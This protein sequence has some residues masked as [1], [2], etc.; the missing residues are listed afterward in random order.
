MSKEK[1]QVRS[2]GGAGKL[3]VRERRRRQQQRQRMTTLL[4]IA[5][6]VLV[7]AGILAAP[8]L[9]QALAPVGEVA[10]PPARTL[11]TTNDNTMGDPNAPVTVVEFS[12]FQ[13]PACRAFFTQ[14]EEPF[15][16]EYV[17]TGKVYFVYRSMGVWIGQESADAAEAAYCAGE[18]NKFWEYH[19]FLFA[20]QTGENVG[21]FLQKR[22]IAFA[23]KIDGL[24]VGAFKDCLNSNKYAQKVNADGAEGRQMGVRGTPTLFV[25]LTGSDTP[26]QP[27]QGVPAMADFRQILDAALQ[28]AGQ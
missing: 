24:D 18:Q 14:V 3:S 27:I 5:G 15:I 8:A 10:V 17:A 20:N 12:D 26:L 4:I 11:P 7:V 16:E 28:Q 19:D 25:Y 2:R 1:K 21:D 9:Q 22:L 6:V 13:C 23:E